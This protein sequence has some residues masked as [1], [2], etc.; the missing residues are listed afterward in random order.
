MSLP[1]HEGADGA[2]IRAGQPWED[3]ALSGLY[4]AFPFD[5]DLPLYQELAREQGGHVLEPACGSGRA[6]VP[7][8]EAGNRI[9][10]L[11]AS[12]HML[13]LAR[14]KLAA[15][16]TEVERRV[17]LQRGDMRS[18]DFGEKFDLAII[19]V[20]SFA[21]LIERSEQQ[22]TLTAVAAHLRPGGLLALDLLHPSPEWLME[23]PGSLRQ[24]QVRYVPYLGATVARTETMVSVDMARQVRVIRSAYEIVAGDGS[25][26]KRIVEWPYRYTYRF[27]AEHLLERAGFDIQAVYG[28]YQREPFVSD[29]AVMLFLARKI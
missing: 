23:A 4:D 12:E 25:V 7:L 20:K 1:H 22:R 15:S 10:G 28:G 5:A 2:F 21:Y 26:K 18:F 6:L 8:A 9:T 19:A 16:G 3:A 11:D 29:S 17:H 27:E 13:A 24:D 14:E